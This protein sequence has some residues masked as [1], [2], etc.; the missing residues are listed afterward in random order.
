MTERD[1]GRARTKPCISTGGTAPPV[2]TPPLRRSTTG[3]AVAYCLVL[4][5]EKNLGAK[6][7]CRRGGKLWRLLGVF[8]YTTAD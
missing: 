8:H 4:T 6:S 5:L 2:S 7:G 1:E 3:V